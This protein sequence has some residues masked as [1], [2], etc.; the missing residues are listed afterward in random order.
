VQIGRLVGAYSRPE[1]DPRF[2]AVTIVVE[3]TIAP[4]VRAPVNPLEISEVRLFERGELPSQL[5]H[6]MTEML[7]DA[8]SGISRFE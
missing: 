1:R 7:H 5:S 2:H 8:L 6:G 3:A 4:P